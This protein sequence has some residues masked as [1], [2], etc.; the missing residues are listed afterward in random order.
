MISDV[1]FDRLY[2]MNAA[3]KVAIEMLDNLRCAYANYANFQSEALKVSAR[4]ELPTGALGALC[5]ISACSRKGAEETFV[6]WYESFDTLPLSDRVYK[7]VIE[8]YK[9]IK[10]SED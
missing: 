6:L 2:K 3:D 10:A 4:Y 7:A 5:T 1:E 8:A 9:D